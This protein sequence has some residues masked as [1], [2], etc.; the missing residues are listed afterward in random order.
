MPMLPAIDTR[1]D[2]PQHPWIS[3]SKTAHGR[4]SEIYETQ[5]ALRIQ[6]TISFMKENLNKPLR[7]ATLASTANMSLPHYF[8]IFKRCTG[9][10]PIDYLI[11]LRVERARELLATTAYS[12]KEIAGIL[13]YDDP[14]YFSRVFKAVNHTTPTQYRMTRR[15]EGL[16]RAAVGM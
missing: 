11:K 5:I 6:R 9:S 2:N 7:A 8:V 16:Q 15:E 1:P 3:A 10:T 4:W 12:V 14:L 13:G